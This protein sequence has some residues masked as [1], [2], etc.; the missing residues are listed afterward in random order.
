M[1]TRTAQA[2]WKGGLKGGTG[3]YKGA[4]ALGGSY[5]FGSRFESASGSNP[6]ELLAAAEAA[7]FSMAL[8][9]NLEK[10]GHAPTKVDTKAACTLEFIDGK[11][12]IT[13]IM[14]DVTAAAQGLDQATLQ[15]IANETKDTCPV[16]RALKGVRIE[17]AAKVG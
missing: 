13:T 8:A 10:Q 14:L 6:E 9:G 7:C 11:P 4:T 3:S 1:P 15:R 5:S 16:S 17:A 12:T 2:T